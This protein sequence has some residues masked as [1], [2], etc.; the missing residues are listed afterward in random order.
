MPAAGLAE[1]AV[2]M[3]VVLGATE[4][5]LRDMEVVAVVAVQV[6]RPAAAVVALVQF[7]YD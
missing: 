3:E 4:E 1:E 7:G 6:H 2:A 5:P